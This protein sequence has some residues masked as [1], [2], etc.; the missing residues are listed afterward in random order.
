MAYFGLDLG[1][2]KI[3][4][5]VLENQNLDS[6][7]CRIRVP[8]EKE[9]GYEHV[10]NQVSLLV[11]KLTK[12]CGHSPEAIGMGSPGSIDP[13]TG[14]LKNC[15]AVVLNE[16]KFHTDLE[17]KLGLDVVL[18]ND[19][20]CFAIAEHRWGA[21]KQAMENAKTSFGI[22]M[23]TG[24][25]GGLVVNNE[26]LNG[27]MGIAGE[28]G[29]NVLIENGPACYCGKNGCVEQV[30][31][32]PAIQRKYQQLSGKQKNLK[33]IYQLYY[34]GDI[35]AQSAIDHLMHFFGKAVSTVINIIDPDVIV[36]GGGVGNIK[37]LYTLGK[38][39]IEE[40]VFNTRFDTA[41]VPP[42]LGDSAGVYGAASLV[43]H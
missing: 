7:L 39:S 17:R 34:S 19:A 26:V 14:L 43:M 35:H 41:V 31:S 30:I 28:W 16:R 4:G 37:E 15:N 38:R 20:N 36:I 9:G 23:G 11:S 21:V 42:L 2:S 3:E 1:G 12:E 40:H 10:L 6:E 18:A 5:V 8:T 29:H 32:G 25:G 33:D 24:V 22:I 27:A 13:F